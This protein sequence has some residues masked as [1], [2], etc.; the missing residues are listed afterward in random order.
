MTRSGRRRST[1][2]RS[3]A[4]QRK[5]RINV[6]VTIVVALACLLAARLAYWQ[7]L[8]HPDLRNEVNVSLTSEENILRPRGNIMDRKGALMA[9]DGTRYEVGIT[10]KTLAKAEKDEQARQQ[11]IQQVAEH[12][13]LSPDYIASELARS[14]DGAHVVLTQ[15]TTTLPIEDGEALQKMAEKKSWLR[16]EPKPYRVYPNGNLASHVLGFVSLSTGCGA[17]GLEEH[18]NTLLQDRSPSAEACSSAKESDLRDLF[19]LEDTRPSENTQVAELV[20]IGMRTLAPTQQGV[21]LVL[22]IDRGIQ[23]LVEKDLEGALKQFGA[24]RG[25]VII[26][27]PKT[28]N[29]LAMANKPDYDPNAITKA[30]ILNLANYAISRQYDPGSTFKIITVANALKSGLFTPESTFHDIG[31]YVFGGVRV[32]NWDGGAYGTVDLTQI[33]GYSLNTGVA[34]L[35]VKLGARRAVSYTLAFGFNERTGIDL[36][37]EIPGVMK[38]PGDGKWTESDLVANAYG[39]GISVTPIQLATAVAAVA[40]GGL[41]M[42]PR[43]VGA[44][45]DH[46]IVRRRPPTVDR[47]VLSPEIANELNQM[48]VDAVGMETEKAVIPGWSIA[49]KTGTADVFINGVMAKNEVIGSFVGWAPA[50]D[51]QFLALIVLEGIQ[52]NEYWGSQSAAPLFQK[53]AWQLFHYLHIAPDQMRQAASGGNGV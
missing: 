7:I 42:R 19:V 22:T 2:Q 33:L 44:I 45:I 1:N 41:L 6:A 47:R 12:L 32:T 29:V 31:E 4:A 11:A 14:K 51:P 26:I 40:N 30:D 5:R 16:V 48:L 49:G 3:L 15:I 28:G 25:T 39:Q 43:V 18:F 10:P 21:D 50:D 27:E 46:G 53:I 8:P 24:R 36:A 34:H 23:Y 52:T 37:G 17:T 13:H 38:I 20:Q 35:N 9:V